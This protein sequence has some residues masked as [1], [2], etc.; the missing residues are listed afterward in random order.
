M[1]DP[2]FELLCKS[3]NKNWKIVDI[4]GNNAKIILTVERTLLWI[5]TILL[6]KTGFRKLSYFLWDQVYFFYKNNFM[7]KSKWFSKAIIWYR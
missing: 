4:F 7:K 2:F 6:G 3:V 1:S 5:V